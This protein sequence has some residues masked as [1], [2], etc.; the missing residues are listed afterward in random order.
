MV[1]IKNNKAVEKLW[2]DV[3]KIQKA[4]GRGGWDTPFPRDVVQQQRKS[5]ESRVRVI[6]KSTQPSTCFM[7]SQDL[8]DDAEKKH[9]E[10]SVLPGSKVATSGTV[11]KQVAVVKPASKPRRDSVS[12]RPAAPKPKRALV[13]VDSGISLKSSSSVTSVRGV[14][15]HLATISPGQIGSWTASWMQFCRL[16]EDHI[17]AYY[18]TIETTTVAAGLRV[19]ADCDNKLMANLLKGKLAGEQVLG[20]NLICEVI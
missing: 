14:H 18:S 15:L 10:K 20:R 7:K 4:S 5:A 19:Y 3:R 17:D 6:K 8:L 2:R 13:R 1:K 12:P 11:Q 9:Q 16:S